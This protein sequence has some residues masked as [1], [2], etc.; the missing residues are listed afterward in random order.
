MKTF[1]IRTLIG[2]L[3]VLIA[4]FIGSKLYPII[5]GPTLSV[6]TLSD[7][8][9]V[10]APMIRISGIAEF[11]QELSVNGES[12][13]LSPKGEFDEK[14]LLNPGYNLITLVGK[15]RYGK[16]NRK[17]FTVML[18]EKAPPEMLTLSTSIPTFTPH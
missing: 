7:G 11:T 16:A 3:G 1:F 18:N 6:A 15:D 5:H 12:F 9:T 14:L 8:A 13:A 10:D 2:S 4:V 17:A